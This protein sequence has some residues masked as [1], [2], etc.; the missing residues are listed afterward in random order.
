LEVAGRAHVGLGADFIKDWVDEL[1]PLQPRYA[2]IGGEDLKQTVEGL[3]RASDLPNLT[4]TLLRRG[5]NEG[6]IRAVLG[7]N[8]LRFLRTTL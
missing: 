5:W 4:A 7:E 2:P 3:A 8:W 1:Y 6:D